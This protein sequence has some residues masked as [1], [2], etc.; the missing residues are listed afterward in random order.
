[1]V[2]VSNCDIGIST[3]KKAEEPA[4]YGANNHGGLC[5]IN[6]KRYIF[7]HRQTNNDWYARQGCAEE[8]KFLPDGSIPQVE[9]T[10]CGLNGGP[11]SDTEEYPSYIVCNMYTDKERIPYVGGHHVPRVTQ[12]GKDGEECVGYIYNIVE[13]TTLGFKY[14]DFKGVKGIELD[15]CGYGK[16]DFEVRTT[17]DGP[18]YAKLG[19]DFETVWVTYKAE[20]NIPDGVSALYLKYTGFGNMGLKSFR[21][22]H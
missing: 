22:L 8:V 15:V 6:G 9:I 17:P 5:E 4:A 14:F 20:C 11:L 13:N 3:Y 19:V 16:G 2:I 12:D 10:S 1:G 7:Y 21:F 18:V